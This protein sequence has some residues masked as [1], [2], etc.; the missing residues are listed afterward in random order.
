MKKI[1]ILT[2]LTVLFFVSPADA[3]TKDE[4]VSHFVQAGFHYRDGRYE[5][6]ADLYEKIAEAGWKS[7]A[8]YYNL[9]NSYFR[10]GE[11]GR[12]VLNYERAALLIPRD[13][14]LRHNRRF[15]YSAANLPP[16]TGEDLFQRALHGHMRFYTFNEMVWIIYAVFL[17]AL[18]AHVFGRVLRWRPGLKT[19]VLS[20]LLIVMTGFAAGLVYKIQ[21]YRDLAFAVEPAEARFEPRDEATTHFR[22]KE[23]SR[24]K[25]VRPQG[26]WVKIRRPDGRLGWVP[27]EALEK[28]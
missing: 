8:L 11:T 3:M 15:V 24:V 12:A 26:P 4:A 18:A 2:S 19:A 10:R 14:D 7:G 22:L 25:I 1:I 20:V 21:Y 17:A 9:G 13:E 6:A 5:E 28:L 27:Q 16:G 23:G